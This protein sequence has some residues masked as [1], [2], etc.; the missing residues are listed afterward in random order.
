MLLA[1]IVMCVSAVIAV[2]TYGVSQYIT[3]D[4]DMYEDAFNILVAIL[5]GAAV[6]FTLSAAYVFAH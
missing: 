2:V 1:R 3:R 6:A 4:G 5:G